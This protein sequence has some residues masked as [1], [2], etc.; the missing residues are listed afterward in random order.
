M[1]A[2]DPVLRLLAIWYPTQRFSGAEEV[3]KAVEKLP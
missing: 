1:L 2:R 3:T